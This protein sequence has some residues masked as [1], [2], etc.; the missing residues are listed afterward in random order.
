MAQLLAAVHDSP[1]DS[2][3]VA[4][5]QTCC[6]GTAHSTEP[7]RP[8]DE[9]Q[10]GRRISD[11]VVGLTC[12]DD[13]GRAGANGI[14]L[15]LGGGEKCRPLRKFRSDLGKVRMAADEGLHLVPKHAGVFE[16]DADRPVAAER[17]PV[18]LQRVW[19]KK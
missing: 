8:L 3:I 9:T 17:V 6:A 12:A 2:M 15:R 14:S 1:S 11:H 18:R 19:E 5:L 10:E 16:E 13:R 7:D 4:R